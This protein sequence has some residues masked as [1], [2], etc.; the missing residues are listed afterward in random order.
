MTSPRNRSSAPSR[1]RAQ[2]RKITTCCSCRCILHLQQY[3]RRLNLLFLYVC[4]CPSYFSSL[5]FGVF[6]TAREPSE[7]KHKIREQKPSGRCTPL[8]PRYDTVGAQMKS[9]K[10]WPLSAET[11]S[12]AEFFNSGKH[13]PI[14]CVLYM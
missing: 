10:K 7:F 9:F 13:F 2:H 12:E 1:L 6:F 14:E 5:I 11:L 4:V 8:F 3:S